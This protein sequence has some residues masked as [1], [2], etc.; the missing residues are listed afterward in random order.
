MG[1]IQTMDI[2]TVSL[3]L[4]CVLLAS[5]AYGLDYTFQSQ[6]KTFRSCD[7]SVSEGGMGKEQCALEMF[8]LAHEP[9]NFPLWEGK[10]TIG[11]MLAKDDTTES[12]SLG[13]KYLRDNFTAQVR[14]SYGKNRS[15]ESLSWGNTNVLLQ[16]RKKLWDSIA[17]SA[18]ENVYVPNRVDEGVVDP[19]RYTSSLKALYPM[20]EDYNLYA[21][22]SYSLLQ[23]PN[24]DASTEFRSPYAFTTG[25]S[26]FDGARTAFNA[27]YA[28]VQGIS[29]SAEADKKIRL[30][31]KRFLN[32]SLKTSINLIKTLATEQPDHQA[33]ININYAF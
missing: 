9:I 11:Y 25:L 24:S 10:A 6:G 16:Y 28:V 5:H 18:S 31:Y 29:P 2:R 14:G 26:Y 22:G 12:V 33:S 30:S 20:N 7:F 8:S 17:I 27:S 3:F 32:K 13:A 23:I 21:E 19:L 1:M 15:D 4:M